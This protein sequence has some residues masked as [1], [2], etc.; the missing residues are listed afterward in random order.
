MYRLAEYEEGSPLYKYLSALASE[1]IHK[2]LENVF[3]TTP[4]ESAFVYEIRFSE[5]YL[6]TDFFEGLSSHI[7][8]R[9]EVTLDLTQ[10]PYTEDAKAGIE[11]LRRKADRMM[12]KLEDPNTYYTFDLFEEYLL[13]TTI[14]LYN[15]RYGK[16]AESEGQGRKA[17]EKKKL[18]AS[19]RETT[20]TLTEAYGLEKKEAKEVA[21]SVWKVEK[22]GPDDSDLFFWDADAEFIFMDGFVAAI[23]NLAKGVGAILGYGYEDIK[24][25]FSDC[26]IEVPLWLAGTEASFERAKENMAERVQEMSDTFLMSLSSISP[27]KSPDNTSDL[28][29]N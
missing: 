1:N 19:I 9:A 23:Q 7:K 12:E 22:M 4:S 27:D 10:R 11:L 20:K 25:I 2:A 26:G 15:C 16:D 29:F 8:E 3:G 21:E 5:D 14:D 13:I 28:P 18:A 17:D 24:T 6:G